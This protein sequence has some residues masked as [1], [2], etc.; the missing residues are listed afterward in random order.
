MNGVKRYRFEGAGGE[1]VYAADYEA[2]VRKNLGIVTTMLRLTTSNNELLR[3]LEAF[4]GF[5]TGSLKYER[6][7]LEKMRATFDKITQPGPTK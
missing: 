7:W 4:P 1:Y 5:D 3:I 6:E 2:L